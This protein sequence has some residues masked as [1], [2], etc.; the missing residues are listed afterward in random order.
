MLQLVSDNLF[1]PADLKKYIYIYALSS[2]SCQLQEAKVSNSVS[3]I[4]VLFLTAV[5]TQVMS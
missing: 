4:N 2:L 1:S 5:V 3:A